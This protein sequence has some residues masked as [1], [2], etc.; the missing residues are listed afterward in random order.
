M[1]GTIGNPLSWGA[2]SAQRAGHEIADSARHV[3]GEG[4]QSVPQVR[5]IGLADIRA[6]VPKTLL[7]IICLFP[8]TGSKEHVLCR[9]RLKG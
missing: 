7:D 6:A 5:P 2:R 1:V 8:A 9:L 3:M 4:D